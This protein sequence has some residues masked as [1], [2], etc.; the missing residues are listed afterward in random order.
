[1]QQRGL[2]IKQVNYD[3]IYD[4]IIANV[5]FDHVNKEKLF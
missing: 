2:T 3:K 5:F 1:M 4:S